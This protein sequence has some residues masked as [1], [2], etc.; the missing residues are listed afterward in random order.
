VAKSLD[1]EGIALTA[2]WLNAV[3][4]RNACSWVAK[5]PNPV[6]RPELSC[7]G[8]NPQQ[9]VPRRGRNKRK[10]SRGPGRKS[11][12]AQIDFREGLLNAHVVT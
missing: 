3:L 6:A 5:M 8:C 12:V 7:K 4:S 1:P 9:T 10:T 11:H 2:R